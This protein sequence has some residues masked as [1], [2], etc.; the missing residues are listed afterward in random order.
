[1]GNKVVLEVGTFVGDLEIL[2][3]EFK[4]EAKYTYYVTCRCSCGTVF[5]V[6]K[7]SITNKDE[8]K[9][10]KSCGC[11]Q[12]KVASK[13]KTAIHVG[14]KYNKLTII[15]DLGIRDR[16]RMVNC[17]C[18]CGN[19]KVFRFDLLERGTTKSCG[20]Y[21]DETRY[22][23]N[24]RHG[25][26]DHEL[27]KIWAS[28]R[29]RCNNPNSSSYAE[30]GG[31]GINVCERWD[32]FSLFLED[33]GSRPEGLSLDRIDPDKGYEPSNCR[34]ANSSVQ[35]HNQRKRKTNGDYNSTSKLKGV[36]Y[37]KFRDKW[38]ARLHYKGK[39]VLRKRFDKEDEA[40]EAYNEASFK[41]YGDT[42]NENILKG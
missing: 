21:Y 13:L 16:R 39:V 29:D 32:D 18:D 28:M 9:R 17:I 33:M 30:Y 41:I 34:W 20:C 11:L 19:E 25:N 22:T 2:S 7:S 5:D 1:M 24:F 3:R 8:S 6:I 38:M 23:S 40:A 4:K 14:A 37:D 27:Y 36:S 35:V 31:R 12:R 10:T 26:C 42:P 15:E